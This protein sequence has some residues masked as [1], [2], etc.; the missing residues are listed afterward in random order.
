M[1]QGGEKARTEGVEEKTINLSINFAND[2]A[3]NG[4]HMAR[5][6][7]LQHLFLSS[8]AKF[9]KQSYLVNHHGHSN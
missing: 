7:N 2:E 4:M 6:T 8:F 3:G 9:V 1:E 5:N